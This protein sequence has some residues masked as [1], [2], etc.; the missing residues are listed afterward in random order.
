MTAGAA[1]HRFAL[2]RAHAA[3]KQIG[4]LGPELA[5]DHSTTLMMNA[6]GWRGVHAIDAMPTATA[7]HFRRPGHPGIPVVALPDDPAAKYSPKWCRCSRPEL[8][9][10]FLFSQLWYPLFSLFMAMPSRCRSWRC[11]SPELRQRRPTSFSAHFVPLS[12]C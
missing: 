7:H 11:C 2:C 8:K 10:Q 5:E 4:G 9:F 3:L 12:A 6:F 1:L